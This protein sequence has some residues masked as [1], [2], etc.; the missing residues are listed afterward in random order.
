MQAGGQEVTGGLAMSANRQ[1]GREVGREAAREM[2][3]WLPFVPPFYIHVGGR[4]RYMLVKALPLFQMAAGGGHA[5][6]AFSD[7]LHPAIPSIHLSIAFLVCV[8]VCII[9]PFMPCIH[10]TC[11]YASSF[12][13]RPV[14]AFFETPLLVLMLMRCCRAHFGCVQ[15]AAT[16]ALS[17]T[18]CGMVWC[19]V[20]HNCLILWLSCKRFCV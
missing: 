9:V 20:V 12:F 11:V 4:F 6:Q 8:C 19:G 2:V 1:T 15:C 7:R 3:L 14:E 17:R 16:D 10:R 13:V 5:V 18:W